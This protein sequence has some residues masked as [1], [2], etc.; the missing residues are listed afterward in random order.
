MEEI[1]D[2]TDDAWMD[3]SKIEDLKAVMRLVESDELEGYMQRM[4][5]SLCER[6][7]ELL[8]Q[9]IHWH[10]EFFAALRED[11]I[12]DEE[13]KERFLPRQK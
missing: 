7:Y 1:V 11:D 4:K 10:I 2:E 3:E 12:T 5:A 13:I 6:D 9:V 8:E